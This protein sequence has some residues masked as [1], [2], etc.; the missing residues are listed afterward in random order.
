MI[1]KKK[2]DKAK[3]QA[4]MQQVQAIQTPDNSPFPANTVTVGHKPDKFILDFKNIYP[5]YS[6]DNQPFLVVAHRM[7]LLDPHVAKDFFAAF[8][9]NMET[10]EKNFGEIKIPEAIK[11]GK[12]L[13]ENRNATGTKDQPS[14]MG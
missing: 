10:Y 12:K 9:A 2:Y 5:Q 13:A 3:Q 8:K 11:K 7:V 14:Y 6:P 4:P 1:D